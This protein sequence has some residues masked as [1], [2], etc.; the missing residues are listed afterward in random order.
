[1]ADT[2]F[3]KE[4][5]DW[6]RTKALPELLK[7]TFSTRNLKLESGGVFE[8]DAVSDDG[9]IVASISTSSSRTSGNNLCTGAIHKLRSDMLFLLLARA[10][11]PYIVLTQADMYAYWMNE[12]ERGRVPLT[13]RFLHTP[14]PD[15]LAQRLAESRTKASEEMMSSRRVRP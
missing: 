7:Q 8:F 3:R 13:I 1:M 11:Q 6:V 10:E 9:I 12:R 2:R 5:E 4:A 15:H 14:L